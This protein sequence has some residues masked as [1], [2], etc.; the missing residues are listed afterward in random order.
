[1][2]SI[3]ER[4]RQAGAKVEDSLAQLLDALNNARAN[5][6]VVNFTLGE[7]SNGKMGVTKMEVLVR[8]P[9]EGARE[10]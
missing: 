2:A 1:M 7:L 8:V 10:H 6:V 4:A 9:H 3:E 5:G